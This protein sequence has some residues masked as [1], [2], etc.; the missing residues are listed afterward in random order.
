M[1]T[2]C[3][4]VELNVAVGME[5]AECQQNPGGKTGP[6]THLHGKLQIPGKSHTGH[7]FLHGFGS[8]FNQFV[9]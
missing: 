2:V 7:R 6:Q 5:G 3:T 4:V 8:K 9:I 1:Q